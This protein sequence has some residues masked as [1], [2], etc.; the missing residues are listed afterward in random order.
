M[1]KDTGKGEETFFA[2]WACSDPPVGGGTCA[3]VSPGHQG[4]V[5]DVL[6]LQAVGTQC[7]RPVKKRAQWERAGT[8]QKTP[9]HP[10]QKAE[11]LS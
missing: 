5:W 10:T 6:H 7:P 8:E 3:D 9:N 1:Q 11:V 2:R 4:G